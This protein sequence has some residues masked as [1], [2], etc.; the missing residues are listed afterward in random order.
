MPNMP[1]DNMEQASL[2]IAG[3]EQDAEREAEKVHMAWHREL[4]ERATPTNEKLYI[5]W[6]TLENALHTAYYAAIQVAREQNKHK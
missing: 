3:W 4:R 1:I 2:I 6:I 5:A